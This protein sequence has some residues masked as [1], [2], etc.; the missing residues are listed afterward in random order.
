MRSRL[1]NYLLAKIGGQVHTGQHVANHSTVLTTLIF[2]SEFNLNI[3]YTNDFVGAF[4][5]GYRGFSTAG[6]RF[7]LITN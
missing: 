6:R 7:Q 3:I 4:C 2:S 1:Y 5:V